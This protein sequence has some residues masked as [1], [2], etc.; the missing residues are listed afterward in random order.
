MRTLG[1]LSFKQT[2]MGMLGNSTVKMV[3]AYSNPKKD[4]EKCF[5][6]GINDDSPRISRLP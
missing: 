4:A 1:P 2:H 3:L 5:Q 6:D